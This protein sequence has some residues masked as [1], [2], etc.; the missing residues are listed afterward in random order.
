MP[1][2]WVELDGGTVLTDVGEQIIRIYH[3]VEG[4]TPAS[5]HQELRAI[6]KLGRD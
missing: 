2:P 6:A 4:L 5:A 3:L 1:E